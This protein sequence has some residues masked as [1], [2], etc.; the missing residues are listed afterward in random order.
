MENSDPHTAARL[1]LH[2]KHTHRFS[3]WHKGT[4]SDSGAPGRGF[5][6]RPAWWVKNAALLQLQPGSD[7][8]PGHSICCEVAQ[9]TPNRIRC[10]DPPALSRALQQRCG[11]KERVTQALSNSCSASEPRPSRLS[12]QGAEYLIMLRFFQL[13][14]CIFHTDMSFYTLYPRSSS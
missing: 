11:R 12:R 4:R 7:P 13:L 14:F 1:E 3:L 6:A 8:W 5:D 10:T 2:L 9:N